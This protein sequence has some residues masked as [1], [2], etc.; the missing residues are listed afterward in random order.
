M[1]QDKGLV[2]IPF[3]DNSKCEKSFSFTRTKGDEH[4]AVGPN[5]QY[6]A[7]ENCGGNI[8]PGEQFADNLFHSKLEVG[9]TYTY[10]VTAV[11]EN[12]MAAMDSMANNKVPPL[13][14]YLLSSAPR[15]EQHVV[16]W[17]SVSQKLFVMHA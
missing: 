12:Y 7:D 3:T 11:A 2:Y 10:C 16:R 4:T 8:Q 5:F 15:C 17:V 13:L 14:P 9:A 1:H 6:Y